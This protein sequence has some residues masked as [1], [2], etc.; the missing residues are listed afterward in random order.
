[1]DKRRRKD[2]IHDIDYSTPG[3]VGDSQRTINN[4]KTIAGLNQAAL[5]KKKRAEGS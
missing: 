4:T 5:P 2:K 3:T 1:M